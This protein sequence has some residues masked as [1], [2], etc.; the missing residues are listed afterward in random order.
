MKVLDRLCSLLRRPV[1]DE[2][3]ASLGNQLDIGDLAALGGEVAAEIGLGDAARKALDEQPGGQLSPR[4]IFGRVSLF[5]TS[6]GMRLFSTSR[7]VHA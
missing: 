4:A 7:G 2:A 6:H 5:W 3:N 1:T